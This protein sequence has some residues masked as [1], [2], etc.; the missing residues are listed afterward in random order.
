MSDDAFSISG[1]GSAGWSFQLQIKDR[2][3]DGTETLADLTGATA[4][5]SLWSG[6]SETP[7]LTVTGTVTVLTATLEF[8][9]TRAQSLARAPEKATGRTG[10]YY[11][12]A[13]VTFPGSDQDGIF[14]GWVEFKARR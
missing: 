6:D 13:R 11:A 5:L 4:V 1:P 7:D 3:D 12:E 2:A 10:R 14:G 9:F 8:T